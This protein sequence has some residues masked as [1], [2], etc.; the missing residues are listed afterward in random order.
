MGWP[1]SWSFPPSWCTGRPARPRARSGVP[2]LVAGVQPRPGP[3]R[4]L[5]EEGLLSAG[6]PEVRRRMHRSGSEPCSRTRRPRS[7]GVSTSAR[8]LLPRRGHARGRCAAQFARLDHERRGAARHRPAR[9]PD[10]RAAGVWPRITIGRDTWIG[11]RAV[12]LAD[13]GSHCVI[14]AGSVVTRP[15]PDYAI[16][17][18]VPAQVVRYRNGVDVALRPEDVGTMIGRT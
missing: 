13:V 3:R 12:V 4:R 9:R 15:I 8:L 16:A 14:G 11:D 18:G 10:P 6:L 7:A 17:V 5:R 1:R 2:W